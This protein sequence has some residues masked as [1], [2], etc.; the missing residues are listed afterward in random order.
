MKSSVRS[1]RAVW[2]KCIVL[3]EEMAHAPLKID[4][5]LH[6][7]KIR[8]EYRTAR[9]QSRQQLS[10]MVQFCGSSLLDSRRA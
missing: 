8:L 10:N 2:A 1:V 3:E 7:T 4:R 6:N 9:W 5:I